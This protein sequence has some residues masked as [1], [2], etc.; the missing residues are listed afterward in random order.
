MEALTNQPVREVIMAPNILTAE[1]LR[2]ILFYDPET[3][4]F[5]WRVSRGSRAKA[6]DAA[7]HGEQSRGYI[8]IRIDGQK[9]RAHRLA[10]LYVH[11]KW[12]ESLVD[13]ING[14]K[15]DN[16]LSNLRLATR[17]QNARNN[18]AT[19]VRWCSRRKWT[20]SISIGCFDSQEEALAARE[21]M[22]K[23]VFGEFSRCAS[24]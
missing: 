18:S 7:G 10:W 14:I 23:F 12:P 2:E 17:A 22:S 20:A 21:L 16:T 9:Y 19:G 4:V 11:G 1:K 24:A 13:H 8:D 6:G 5:Y 15:T 3:G